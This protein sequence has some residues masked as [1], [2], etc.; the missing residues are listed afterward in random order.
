MSQFPFFKELVDAAF[1]VFDSSSKAFMSLVP[2]VFLARILLTKLM[3]R[4]SIHYGNLIRDLLVMYIGFFF[5]EEVVR[6]VLNVPEYAENLVGKTEPVELKE[7][8]SSGTFLGLLGYTIDEVLGYVSIIA[9]WI[10]AFF[11]FIFMSLMICFGGAVV[12]FSTMFQMRW[13]ASAF[14]IIAA[15]LSMWPFMWYIVD[16]SVAEILKHIVKSDSD[17]A[18]FS[19]NLGG[20]LIKIGVPF[21][22]LG[23]GLKDP[24]RITNGFKDNIK[25]SLS[26]INKAGN[27]AKNTAKDAAHLTGADK[28]YG[29]H[30]TP[31][32][33]SAKGKTLEFKTKSLKTSQKMAPLVSYGLGKSLN[34]IN[35][36]KEKREIGRKTYKSFTN[37]SS[38][39]NRRIDAQHAQKTK[40]NQNI[41][42]SKTIKNSNNGEFKTSSSF[43]RNNSTKDL[44]PEF[45]SALKKAKKIEGVEA[46]KL[47]QW[48]WA[49]D[50]TG[51]NEQ[52]L[53]QLGFEYSK[54]KNRWYVG[55]KQEGYVKS[56]KSY[57]EIQTFYKKDKTK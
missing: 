8:K 38:E 33:E 39:L 31:R 16:Q 24:L 7:F 35:P 32:I 40:E 27:F 6:F 47:G 43:S 29:G 20:N 21:V 22:G 46:E 1:L 50:T 56:D 34:K 28:V 23:Y 11:Y 3:F 44:K 42:R 14:F 30:V 45:K 25:S 15:M 53:Q 9:Y 52:K 49:K 12:F 10:M 41:K 4:S 19:T 18:M 51:K 13:M 36:S 26:P 37:Y 5:F 55:P 48:V 54:D 2:L 57:E 17:F